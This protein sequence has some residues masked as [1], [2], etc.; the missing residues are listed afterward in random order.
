M[1]KKCLVFGS[2]VGM[3]PSGISHLVLAFGLETTR[4][5]VIPRE[6]TPSRSGAISS[7]KISINLSIPPGPWLLCTVKHRQRGGGEEERGWPANSAPAPPCV[8]VRVSSIFAYVGK[9]D[10]RGRKKEK[11]KETDWWTPHARYLIQLL[12]SPT[13]TVLTSLNQ[14]PNG[15][16]PSHL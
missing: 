3:I 4:G 16:V 12:V 2:R 8:A 6:K 14:T 11:G 15:I 1:I 10:G 9:E 7:S 13:G 5:R